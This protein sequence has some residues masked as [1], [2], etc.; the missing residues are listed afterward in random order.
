MT[1]VKAQKK[2][3]QKLS[4]KRETLRTLSKETLGE[5]AFE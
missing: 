5:V 1:K 3:N 2:P 4:L